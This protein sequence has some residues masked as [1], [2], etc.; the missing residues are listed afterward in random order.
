MNPDKI[1]KSPIKKY[2]LR[3]MSP[4]IDKTSI[5]ESKITPP[6]ISLK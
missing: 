2:F 1:E 5:N 4:Y 6:V 3:S